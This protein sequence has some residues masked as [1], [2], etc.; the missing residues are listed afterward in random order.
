M[1]LRRGCVVLLLAAFAFGV[2]PSLAQE[3]SQEA[4]WVHVGQ[5]LSS[6]DEVRARAVTILAS[7]HDLTLMAGINDILYYSFVG[8]HSALARQIADLM[9][10]M[11]GDDIGDNP[12]RGWA[13]WV[14]RR[15]DVR[16]KDG[17][18]AFKRSVFVRYDQAFRG[19]LNPRFTFR[20]RAEEIEW[21]GVRK[22]G[23][24]ALDQPGFV[25]ASEVDYLEDTDRVFGVFL[26]GEAKAYPH[27]ILDAHEM[28]NDLVGGAPVS[29]SYCTLCGSGVLYKGDHPSREGKAPF[30]FG[31]SG[32][33]YRS[34]KLMYDRPTNSLWNNLTG[35]PVSGRLA[36]SGIQL[37]RLPL[38]VSTWGE[39]KKKHPNTKV[40][41]ANATGF[42]HY[43]YSKSPYQ[44]YFDSND[45]M[46]PVWLRSEAL[47]TKQQ[48]FTLIID[49]KPKAY[50][51]DLLKQ[52]GV[53]HD[54]LG[55]REIVLFTN[56]VSGAVRAYEAGDFRFSRAAGNHEVAT[57]S[58]GQSWRLQEDKLQ[59]DSGEELLRLAGHNAFWFGW[60][61]FYPSTEI[62]GQ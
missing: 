11:S 9:Q 54:T 13:E 35:E 62:Y 19:Y 49:G 52:E 14:G 17:Y 4:G 27:R 26:N 24:P 53:S 7:S 58:A 46:F 22:D 37:E 33:L 47:E 39:W 34:N 28:C 41:D 6:N 48:V 25:Q 30:T 40:L 32:L 59:S 10:T 29:L 8:R 57:D 18:L 43:D 51:L 12:R 45:T 20:I 42:D 3:R 36:E 61:A 16:P 1:E 31:S 15:Q 55:G 5:L 44:D 2:L 56:P 21:G 23:I 50:P 38:V 60:F